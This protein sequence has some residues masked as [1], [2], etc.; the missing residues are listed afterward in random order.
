M[1]SRYVV[2][3]FIFLSA[4]AT[5]AHADTTAPVAPAGLSEKER[6]AF[7]ALSTGIRL[8]SRAYFE[9][10]TARPQTIGYGMTDS[11]AALAAFM[12][13]HIGFAQWRY[14]DD[15]KESPTKDEVLDDFT[16]YWLTNSAARRRGCLGK[17][18]AEALRL[19]PRRRPTRSRF[20]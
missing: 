14:N 3:F 2:P 5:L 15:P 1:I 13:V 9:M 19:R 10:L 20:P 6:A 7:D 4:V 17:T 11:P 18:K 16:L 8:G 12:L